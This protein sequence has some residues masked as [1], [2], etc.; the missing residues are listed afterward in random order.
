MCQARQ[1]I[2]LVYMCVRVSILSLSAIFYSILELF[3]FHFIFDTKV[4]IS[5]INIL[6]TIPLSM[7]AMQTR[8]QCLV[9]FLSP[10]PFLVQFGIPCLRQDT[11]I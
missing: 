11:Q 6:N 3:G 4:T 5:G 1:V 2:R 10:Q 8:M 7:M 9:L